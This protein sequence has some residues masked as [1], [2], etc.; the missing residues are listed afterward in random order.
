MDPQT[1]D[2]FMKQVRDDAEFLQ[3]Q[4]LMDYSLLVSISPLDDVSPSQSLSEFEH[5]VPSMVYF[6]QKRRKQRRKK[7]DSLSAPNIAAPPPT[8]S[9]M[10]RKKRTA[11]ARLMPSRSL[12]SLQQP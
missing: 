12:A 2:L 5:V 4:N 7:P 9:C 10:K 6:C 11:R 1:R 8:Y 3:S